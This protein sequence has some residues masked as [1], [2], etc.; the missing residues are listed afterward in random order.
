LN[1]LH[2]CDGI[3]VPAPWGLAAGSNNLGRIAEVNFELNPQMEHGEAPKPTEPFPILP[4]GAD[5]AIRP[6]VDVFES[7]DFDPATISTPELPAGIEIADSEPVFMG[8]VLNSGFWPLTMGVLLSIIPTLAWVL[9]ALWS[10]ARIWTTDDRS[11]TWQ[12]GWSIVVI[13]LPVVGALAYLAVA[14][15]TA[16]RLR[17]VGIVGVGV[18]AW[19]A[20]T[21]AAVVIG[22]IV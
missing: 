18:F 13:V 21:G 5:A 7:I 15:R 16:R 2:S 17:R 19:I 8:I 6:A 4:G 11:R 10:L 22:G 9:G 14:D 20:A 12:V 1:L 3:N